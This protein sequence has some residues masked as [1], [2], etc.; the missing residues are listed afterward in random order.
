MKQLSLKS[1]RFLFSLLFILVGLI[2]FPFYKYQINPDGIAYLS[3]AQ[4]YG[5]GR[6][7]EALNSCWPPMISWLLA[8][9]RL[10]TD[11]L[12][13]VFKLYNLLFGAGCLWVSFNL[14]EHFRVKRVFLIIGMFLLSATYMMWAYSIT[15]PDLLSVW[16]ILFYSYKI[17]TGKFLEQ[18]ILTGTLGALAYFAKSYCFFFFVAHISFQFLFY[19]ISKKSKLKN[20]LITYVKTMAVLAFFVFSW[21][22]L[23]YTKYGHFTLSSASAYTHALLK[24]PDWKCTQSFVP[25]PGPNAV[26][27]W[28][29]PPFV[30]PRKDWNVFS[31]FENLELQISYIFKNTWNLFSMQRLNGYFHF[32]GF[33][34]MLFILLFERRDKA[35]SFRRW[36]QIPEQPLF[37]LFPLIGIY[38]MGYL[39]IFIEPRYVWS[40][41]AWISIGMIVALQ[42]LVGDHIFNKGR[43]FI[44]TSIL[45][46][47]AIAGII[48]KQPRLLDPIQK[49]FGSKEAKYNTLDFYNNCQQLKASMKP[50]TNMAILGNST[51]KERTQ[52]SSLAYFT[53]TR[54]FGNLP[55][56]PY[57]TKRLID[58]YSIAL[59]V[60]VSGQE[61]SVLLPDSNWIKLSP[62]VGNLV[63]YQKKK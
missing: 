44:I 33:L 42:E 55:S 6:W 18:P 46:L 2:L 57:A 52:A 53:Q 16:I 20:L 48:Y 58:Q 62:E 3:I 49:V 13:W 7:S 45:F 25:P 43:L 23:L 29:D 28:E 5:S 51:G 11:E 59:L 56:D 38:T 14:L 21:M 31:S 22:L 61:A 63:V 15:T 41:Y 47:A 9:W 10:V 36:K 39:L 26:F 1:L 37:D 35:W 8:P 4:H 30:C 40:A 17:V 34:M 12:L 32:V 24:N 54:L 50:G 19:A 60:V 27:P